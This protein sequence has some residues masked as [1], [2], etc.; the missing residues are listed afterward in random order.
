MATT[1]ENAAIRYGVELNALRA[2]LQVEAPRGGFNPDGTPVTLFEGHKFSRW[3]GGIWDAKYPTISYPS[4]TKKFYGHTWQAEQSRLQAAMRL[5]REAA[6]KSTS[7][8]K[9]QILGENWKLCDCMDLQEFVNQMY[10]SEES[11]ISLFI[12][13]LDSTNLIKALKTKN[14][15]AFARGYNGPAYKENKYD[16]KLASAYEHLNG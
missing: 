10:E 13:F 7:W 14:W 11:Q 5:D 9:P 15:A 16:E 12:N 4:W 8:G 3:T 6:I 1:L 2:V